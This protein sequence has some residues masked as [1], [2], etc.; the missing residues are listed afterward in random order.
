MPKKKVV[1]GATPATAVAVAENGKGE[2][3]PQY[4]LEKAL[5]I[6]KA[7][8]EKNGGNPWAVTAIAEALGLG[9][10][11]NKLFYLSAASRDYGLTSGTSR[12]DKISLTDFG[13]TVFYPTSPQAE[14]A[15]LVQAFKNVKIFTKVL[16]HYK[17]SDL[18]QMKYLGS[19]LKTEFGLAE[20]H[21]EL[22]ARVFKEN[23]T[24]LKIGSVPTSEDSADTKASPTAVVWGEPKSAVDLN[25][26]AFVVMP[27]VERNEKRARGF[28]QEVL[29]SIITPA[30]TKAGFTVRT[31]NRQGSDMIQATI[32]NELINADLVITDLT[33]S[34]PNVLFELGVR[35]ALK[36]PVALIKSADTQRLF[37]VDNIIRIETYSPNLWPS[38]IESDLER[39]KDHIVAAW[40][41]RDKANDYITV[42]SGAAKS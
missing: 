25:K 29:T 32:I 20:K 42:L 33:D 8:K 15:T 18:P 11:G 24:F 3:F 10:E 41:G 4:S 40:E 28:H 19:T 34:N 12:T 35:L 37:D 2:S 23:C 14:S 7:I 16:D 39:I 38:T 1:A 31:A 27:F 36:K 6:G 26:R 9:A 22:F 13:K 30:G 5:A 17:G 21:H